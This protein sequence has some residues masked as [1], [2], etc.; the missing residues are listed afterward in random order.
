MPQ[1]T[2]NR[3][4]G[5]KKC[6]AYSSRFTKLYLDT[7][8][9]DLCIRNTSDIRNDREDNSSMPL[10]KA[11]YRQFILPRHGRLGKG[12]INNCGTQLSSYLFSAR[13]EWN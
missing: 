9:L 8:V 3:C 7:D 6:I 10:R 13:F 4:C 2:E 1:E 11:A 12:I 5:M